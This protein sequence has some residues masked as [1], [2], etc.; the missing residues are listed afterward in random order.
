MPRFDRLEFDDQSPDG[1][2][3]DNRRLG[4]IDYGEPRD[5]HHWMRLADQER[6]QGNHENALRFYSRALE[7][8]KSIVLAWVG[9][10]Q[11][12]VYLKEYPEA[13]LWARKA[14]EVFKNHAD[15]LAGRAHAFCRM[16]DKKQAMGTC[17]Q[18][19]SQ[20][21]ESA[22]RW[23]VR[24]ELMLIS[25]DPLDRHCFDKATRADSDWL[26]QLEIALILL[27]YKQ[28]NK[29]LPRLRSAIEQEPE[30]PYL[31]WQRAQCENDLGLVDAA[32]L[33]CKR[34]LEMVPN[35]TYARTLLDQLQARSS[36]FLG[37]IFGMFGK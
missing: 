19:L 16:G 33:S 4:D 5:E 14:L 28:H 2:P 35:H 7:Y 32:K 26:V 30:S 18:A 20:P 10:V 22:Y 8:D 12:L 23:M 17:D 6:R 36:G 31:W 24:A 29:A 37:R 13:E 25:K 27:H 11:M 15:L 1:L 34:C 9:Q 21:G 3:D